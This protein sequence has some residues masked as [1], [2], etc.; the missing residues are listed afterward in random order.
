MDYMS[1]KALV[2]AVSLIVTMMIASAVLYSVNQIINVYKQVYE[3]DTSIKSAIDEFDEYDG[4]VKTKLDLLNTAKKYMDNGSVIV[5]TSSFSS[6]VGDNSRKMYAAEHNK[7][8]TKNAIRALNSSL[9]VEENE[10]RVSV[11]NLNEAN[12]KYG[13]YVMKLSDG[14]VIVGFNIK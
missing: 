12:K 11:R 14:H 2:I 7:V 6:V 1:N 13:T 5:T 8:N 4:T 9:G 10:G 3:T